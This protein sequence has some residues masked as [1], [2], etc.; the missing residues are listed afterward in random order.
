MPWPPCDA[1]TSRDSNRRA[2]RPRDFR[3]R[4]R[5]RTAAAAHRAARRGAAL[6]SFGRSR[7]PFGRARAGALTVACRVHRIDC[8]LCADR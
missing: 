7:A 8:L 3:Q 2:T 5:E 4:L 6:G 1:G